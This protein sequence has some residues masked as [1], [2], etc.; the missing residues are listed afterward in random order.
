MSYDHARSPRV[1]GAVGALQTESDL[2]PQIKRRGQSRKKAQ[3]P[4]TKQYIANDMGLSEAQLRRIGL[5]GSLIMAKRCATVSIPGNPH[6]N[7]S[8]HNYTHETVKKHDTGPLFVVCTEA[9]KTRMSL[10]TIRC[11]CWIHTLG[12]HMRANAAEGKRVLPGW[13]GPCS[14][15]PL[16]Q[17]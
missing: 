1:L 5:S 3:Y 10:V 11:S 16:K 12:I 13:H 6:I 2:L 4:S 8:F 7:S 17:L 14:V 9:E 15:A